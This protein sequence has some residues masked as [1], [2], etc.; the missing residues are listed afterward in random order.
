MKTLSWKSLKGISYVLSIDDGTATTTALTPSGNPFVTQMADS[1]DFYSPIREQTGNIGVVGEVN[2]MEGLLASTPD[3]RPVTLTATASGTT[4]TVWKGYLQTSAF[5]QP[6][7]KGPNDIS[8]PVVSHLGII[9]SY[10]FTETGYLSFADFIGRMNACTG[11]A[12]Y[13]SFVFPILMEPLTTLEYKFS[14][15]N[16]NKWNDDKQAYDYADYK[17]VLEEFCKVFGLVAMEAGDVLYFIAPDDYSGCYQFT[18][19]NLAALA[20]GDDPTYT[21]I[22]PES[23]IG[24]IDGADH[25]ISYQAG[26]KSIK[27]SGNSN[28]MDKTLYSLDLK[29]MDPVSIDHGQKRGNYGDDKPELMVYYTKNYDGGDYITVLNPGVNVRYDS[30][31]SGDDATGSSLVS[32]RWYLVDSAIR[33]DSYWQDDTGWMNQVVFKGNSSMA[34]TPVVTIHTGK[35]LERTRVY[36]DSYLLVNFTVKRLAATGAV[37]EDFTGDL[38][39]TVSVGSDTLYSDVCKIKDG[40]TKSYG[41]VGVMMDATEGLIVKQTNG[42]FGSG[43]VVVTIAQPEAGDFWESLDYL[44]WYAISN[45]KVSLSNS[46]TRHLEDVEETNTEERSIESGFTEELEQSNAFTT[47]RTDQMGYGIILDSGLNTVGTLYASKTPEAAL[48]DRMATYYATSKQKL[49]VQ[50]EGQGYLF[51][52]SSRILPGAGSV[53]TCLAQTMN[54]RDDV[55]EVTLFEP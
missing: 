28:P 19:A 41:E 55:N 49:R 31:E 8:L 37:Y 5:S 35:Y 21:Y 43:E 29:N 27:V 51:P 39:V 47:Y 34:Q 7:D 13:S 10:D 4:S 15:L 20:N 3:E 40:T 45:I 2:V 46:W 44:Y 6:W 53:M 12:F 33:R 23:V 26:K 52:P 38:Y 25:D 18:A 36:G 22:A 50:L 54:W 16:F 32:E 14:G 11:T 24:V 17:E 42:Y 48:A 9:E 30:W 1:D